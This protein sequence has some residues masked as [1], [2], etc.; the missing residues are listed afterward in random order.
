MHLRGLIPETDF[1]GLAVIARH[2]LCRLVGPG[3]PVEAASRPSARRRRRPRAAAKRC[4]T[5]VEIEQ[6]ARVGQLGLDVV[7]MYRFGQR[8]PR[9]HGRFLGESASWDAGPGHGGAESVASE[10]VQPVA[11]VQG[12]GPCPYSDLGSLLAFLT[13]HDAPRESMAGVS[14]L[15]GTGGL[16]RW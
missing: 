8:Q 13:G 12:P 5:S 2:L 4:Q 7:V 14:S 15:D 16:A 10:G 1:M 3:G 11:A 6:R 9:L